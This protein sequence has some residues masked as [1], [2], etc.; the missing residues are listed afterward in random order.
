M[1]LKAPVPTS[2]T[3]DEHFQNASPV[4]GQKAHDKNLEFLI[5]APHDLPTNLDR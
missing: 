4:A 5:A 1:V 3:C 2:I